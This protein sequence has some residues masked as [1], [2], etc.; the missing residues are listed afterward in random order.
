MIEFLTE[1]IRTEFHL[2]PLDRQ[3][4]IRELAQSRYYE[5]YVTTVTFVDI[6]TSTESE[7]SVRI[8]K[9]FNTDPVS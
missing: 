4:E 8:D 9:K 6:I 1:E 7:V 2:L 5:G 3:R